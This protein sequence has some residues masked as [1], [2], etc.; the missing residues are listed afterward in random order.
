M[1]AFRSVGARLALALFVIV[2]GVLGVVYLLV[3]PYL[4]ERLIDFRL[5]QLERAAPL[6]STLPD[7]QFD[8]N[9]FARFTSATVN[10]RVVI[11]EPLTRASLQVVED[12]APRS[13]DVVRDGVAL[14][15][16]AAGETVRGTVARADK[17]FAE[18]AFP[19][20]PDGP[21]ILL[22]SPLDDAFATVGFVGSRFL[23]AAAV[24]LVASLLIGLLAA[25]FFAR[26]I[27][28]L[29]RAA[30]RIASG[31]FD[32][33]VVDT[34]RDEL[35]ELARAFEQMR[36][37]LAQLDRARSEFIA[38]ASHELRTPVFSLGGFLELLAD[39]DLDEPTRREFLVIAREQVERLGKLATDLL[40]L[41]RLDAGRLTVERAP[42][43]LGGLAG[44]LTE[45][46]RAVAA[47]GDHRLVAASN[48][49]VEALGDEQR[50]FQIGRILVE[51]ALVHTP[52]GTTIR[53]GAGRESRAARL[54]VEDDGPGIAP[55]QASHVFERFYRGDGTQASGSGLGL[56]I[57]RELAELMGGAITLESGDR[58]TRFSL[59]LPGG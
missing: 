35:G 18:V 37:R 44:E 5:D 45:E 55:D 59:T 30:E 32:E 28:R 41:S 48:G 11:Y 54:V 13:E 17:R 20:T 26:R 40:D 50:V 3:V 38:N 31:R 23:V 53:V 14:R 2:A 8:W 46:F 39:E 27:R 4:K 10:A 7:S 36:L 21:F 58:R 47:A 52:P 22:S 43:D 42:V 56:A 16:L 33:P 12:S 24:A 57:A 51:N 9:D 1:S 25:R 29:E 15:A 6:V 19:I 49:R 34:G